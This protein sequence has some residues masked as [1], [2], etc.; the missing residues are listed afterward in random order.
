[1]QLKDE[2]IQVLKNF[3]LINP[4]MVIREGS[5]IKTVAEAKNVYAAATV[6]DSFPVEFGIYDLNEFLSVMSIMD[7]PDLVFSDK[8]VTINSGSGRSKI[9]YYFTD[10]DMLTSP[11]RLV[12]LPSEYEI[13]F[14]L[15]STTLG[16]IKTA[17]ST[18][19]HN[20]LVITPDN[21][22]LRLTVAD[23]ENVTSNTFSIDVPGKYDQ[24]DSFE[25]I[26][27]I[28]NIKKLVVGDYN[29]Q[30]SSKLVS[31]FESTSPAIEYMV[32]LEK[33]SKYGK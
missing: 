29:V 9:K 6:Q 26:L 27:N 12:K 13:E 16:R 22:S 25:L 18:L 11:T 17:A 33:N 23:T 20:E 8:W 3:A 4:N 28:T 1:M 30:L 2:T 24:S 5:E 15:D 21:G 7:N 32:A 10:P 31:R 19:G 14:R